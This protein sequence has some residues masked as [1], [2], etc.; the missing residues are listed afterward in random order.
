MYRIPGI[1]ASNEIINDEKGER[2]GVEG[3]WQN[4][5]YYDFLLSEHDWAY[6][7]EFE[8]WSTHA[9]GQNYSEALKRK[10]SN[11]FLA[12][13]FLDMDTYELLE[14][15][16]SS[17]DIAYFGGTP[18]QLDELV[19]ISKSFKGIIVLTLGSEGSI[20]INK[21]ETCIQPALP[22]NRV[23]DT[24]GCGDA[25]QSAFAGNYLLTG[26]IKSSLLRGAEAGKTAAM[27]YGAVCLE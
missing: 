4:G 15:G 14:K 11:N 6:I 3:A 25:F 9:N 17:I 19:Y 26:D 23:I 5:V 2:F 22:L 8:I 1:T 18:N 24:T 27:K 12:V 10:R 7:E 20:A 21:G 13:D 16:L